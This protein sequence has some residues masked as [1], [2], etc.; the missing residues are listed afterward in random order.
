MSSRRLYRRRNGEYAFASSDSQWFGMGATQ[1]EP[2]TAKEA[3]AATGMDAMRFSEHPVQTVIEGFYG[4]DDQI[5]LPQTMDIPGH[6]AVVLEEVDEEY[7]HP[8]TVIGREREVFQFET[9]IEPLESV[10][11]VT[12]G[13]I[14]TAG[15]FANGAEW[16]GFVRLPKDVTIG[17]DNHAMYLFGRDGL[18]SSFSV[19]PHCQRM[20]CFNMFPSAVAAQSK[21]EHRYVL[22]HRR[23]AKV[24]VQAIRESVQLAY[25]AADELDLAASVLLG[26]EF[27]PEEF[28]RYADSLLG[29]PDPQAGVRAQTN[30]STR[31]AALNRILHSESTAST[32]RD[33]H[34]TK[35][36]AFQAITEYA[37][38]K[39]PVRSTDKK[40]RRV[41][42]LVEGTMDSLKVAALAA[43][44]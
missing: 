15:L 14:E 40:A 23:G 3:L 28:Y 35:W 41:E 4:P 27:S 9:L 8:V 42:R 29:A 25:D 43:L 20:S 32:W 44:R 12:E 26:E 24:N 6:K 36:T 39:S 30:H 17:G 33:G 1:T 21:Y 19:G 5:M 22:Q 38:H 16:F 11:D 34:M 13:V 2:M 18:K 37:D 31:T 10:L 7:L